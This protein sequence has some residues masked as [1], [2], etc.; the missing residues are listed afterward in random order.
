MFILF[1]ISIYEVGDLYAL[2]LYVCYRVPEHQY[3][4]FQ[5]QTKEAYSWSPMLDSSSYQ[6]LLILMFF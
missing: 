2:T 3:R 1:Y 5:I 4:R 6:R